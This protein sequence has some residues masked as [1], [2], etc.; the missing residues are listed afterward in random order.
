MKAKTTTDSYNG[1]MRRRIT[2]TTMTKP[3]FA[4]ESS[5]L[6]TLLTAA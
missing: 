2:A 1:E 3:D 4:A 6:L 5:A